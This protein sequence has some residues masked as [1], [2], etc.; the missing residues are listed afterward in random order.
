MPTERAQPFTLIKKKE[1]LLPK[2]K[3]DNWL[4]GVKKF[5]SVVSSDKLLYSSNR[6]LTCRKDTNKVDARYSQEMVSLGERV[7]SSPPQTLTVTHM[8]KLNCNVIDKRRY[9]EHN[10]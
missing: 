7:Q 1:I 3:I 8:H 9:H 5:K 6:N 4:Q 10:P 2:I